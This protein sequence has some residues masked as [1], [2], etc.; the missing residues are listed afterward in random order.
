M[1]LVWEKVATTA[2]KH[3]EAAPLRTIDPVR[4]VVA[5]LAL[6]SAW[7]LA[8]PRT[9]DRGASARGRRSGARRHR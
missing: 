2:P 3:A 6:M 5:P 7:L 4:V 9:V 1:W 8:G